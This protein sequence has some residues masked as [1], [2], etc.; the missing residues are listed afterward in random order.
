MKMRNM[1]LLFYLM[2]FP[3]LT[4]HSQDE[5]II[6]RQIDDLKVD[7]YVGEGWAEIGDDLYEARQLSRERAVANLA[8][9][10]EVNVRSDVESILIEKPDGYGGQIEQEFTQII[11][12]YT[13][14]AISNPQEEW[15]LYY[16]TPNHVATVVWISREEYQL[17]VS[18]DMQ[19]KINFAAGMIENGMRAFERGDHLIGVSHWIDAK[20]FVEDAFGRLP[21][22]V[23]LAGGELT[24]EANSYLNRK[25]VNFFGNINLFADS[26]EYF[27]DSE[28]RVRQT[29]EV[30]AQY[31]EGNQK[32]V[33]KNL[34][35]NVEFVRG[36]GTVDE[37]ITTGIHGQANIGIGS[38]DPAHNETVLNVTVAV[39]D[40]LDLF[41]MQP[42]PST[43]ITL[44]R[45]S[46]AAL[47]VSAS[48]VVGNSEVQGLWGSLSTMI[49]GGGF[50]VV[51]FTI[52]GRRPGDSDIERARKS[53]A[54]YLLAV[55]IWIDD[56]GRVQDF[57]NM[58]Y[59]YCSGVIGFYDVTTGSLLH[60]T[61]ISQSRGLGTTQD[62][63]T[64]QAYSKVRDNILKEARNLPRLM[65]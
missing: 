33:V 1:M 43:T 35:L 13:D 11:R 45:L 50:S 15:H 51:E 44:K 7:N 61:P 48:G 5:E 64:W 54:D 36:S 34:Q 63:A 4:V 26:D 30:F 25:V 42:L 10:I 58:F 20:K 24:E 60:E 57:E 55:S 46:T 49:G 31:I 65:K 9:S 27:Y 8:Q 16:P 40:G 47:S 52:Q 12:T 23:Q 6:K 19:N 2:L 62:V 59:A 37:Q 38:V 56:R 3:G 29:P 39:I 14:M 28:G 32:R 22:E 21:V 53:F 18:E 17:K 41:P